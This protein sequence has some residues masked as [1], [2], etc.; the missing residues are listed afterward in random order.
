MS[1]P[2]Y[3][4]FWK[5]LMAELVSGMMCIWIGEK[6]R[7]FEDFLDAILEEQDKRTSA[8]LRELILHRE[9]IKSFNK[10]LHLVPHSLHPIES[11]AH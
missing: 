8:A 3:I 6:L 5:V 2:W 11:V 7:I 1:R 4:P 9:K 10:P